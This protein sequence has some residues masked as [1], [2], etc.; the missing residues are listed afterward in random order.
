MRG[1]TTE[2]K[3]ILDK[4][5]RGYREQYGSSLNS[6]SKLHPAIY[7]K[8]QSI[9]PFET[10]YQEINIYLWDNRQMEMN[11]NTEL[12]LYEEDDYL[13]IV[14]GQIW[15]VSGNNEFYD[16]EVVP[17]KPIPENAQVTCVKIIKYDNRQMKLLTIDTRDGIIIINKYYYST[18]CVKKVYTLTLVGFGYDL[19]KI[20]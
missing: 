6:V 9:N 15:A 20:G 18:H 17:P 19:E 3:L 7:D 14:N 16:I 13:L 8:V 12:H 4:Q 5:R 11:T 1:L 2:Q 10:I